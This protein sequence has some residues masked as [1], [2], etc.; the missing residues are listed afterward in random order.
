[1]NVHGNNSASPYFKMFAANGSTGDNI[2]AGSGAS[3][4]SI[5]IGTSANADTPSHITV[6]NGSLVFGDTMDV[7]RF[8]YSSAMIFVKNGNFN[9]D[10][11]GSNEFGGAFVQSGSISTINSS[12]GG[13]NRY[14]VNIFASGDFT[15]G[16]TGTPT[17]FY[18]GGATGT[19][20]DELVTGGNIVFNNA[21]IGTGTS[22]NVASPSKMQSNNG[23][24]R[25]Q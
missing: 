5:N 15:L 16:V 8:L 1:M 11:G 25:F 17:T 9:Y 21:L 14:G 10:L 3:F 18:M 24:I 6:E 7:S 22:T 20:N 23:Y 2:Y 13:T 4:N 12:A 19:S